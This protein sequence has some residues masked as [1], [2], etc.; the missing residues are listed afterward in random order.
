VLERLWLLVW[1]LLLLG[2]FGYGTLAWIGQLI[3]RRPVLILDDA[4]VRLPPPWPRPRTADRVLAWE[5]V[6][7]VHA[8]TQVTSYRGGIHRQHYLAFVPVDNLGLRPPSRLERWA[9]GMAGAPSPEALRYSVHVQPGWTA[10]V[11]QV[12]EATRARKPALRWVDERDLPRRRCAG[13]CAATPPRSGSP[14]P[15][16][17]PAI[18]PQAVA[19]S[20]WDLVQVLTVALVVSLLVLVYWTPWWL[21]ESWRQARIDA[22][23]VRVTGRIIDADTGRSGTSARATY[24]IGGRQGDVSTT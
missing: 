3:G 13:G 21:A 12:A 5:Q 8:F 23:Q 17:E 18:R 9:A 10:M 14:R 1:G 20:R 15:P 22:Y 24:T 4:G 2:V 11:E 7:R 6:A 16:P 19:T